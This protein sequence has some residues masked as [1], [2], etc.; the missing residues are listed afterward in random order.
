M[1][2]LTAAILLLFSPLALADLEPSSY[3]FTCGMEDCPNET[4]V[5]DY[6]S[7]KFRHI[8]NDDKACPYRTPGSIPFTW[9]GPSGHD[10]NAEVGDEI[11][12]VIYARDLVA[13][14]N[15]HYIFTFEVTQTWYPDPSDTDT[16]GV[17]SWTQTTL[18]NNCWNP[19]HTC[20]SGP[21]N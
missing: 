18:H 15:Y 14:R 2:A 17:V 5:T 19:I 7:M 13:C 6:A 9:T 8:L 12:I 3:E 21:M 4:E 11:T 10:C 16:N 1:K 20:G